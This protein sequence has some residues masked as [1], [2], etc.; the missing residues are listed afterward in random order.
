[1]Y[2]KGQADAMTSKQAKGAFATTI[3]KA[4]YSLEA[5]FKLMGRLPVRSPVPHLT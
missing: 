2:N 5:D 3:L 4:W 1:M